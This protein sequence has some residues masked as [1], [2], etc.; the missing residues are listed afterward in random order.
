MLTTNMTA[1][2]LLTYVQR[3]TTNDP[4]VCHYYL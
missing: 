1:D 3:R 4:E 2:S